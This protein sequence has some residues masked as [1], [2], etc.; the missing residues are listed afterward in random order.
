MWGCIE[1]CREHLNA[2]NVPSLYV[3]VYRHQREGSR[4]HFRSLTVCEGVSCKSVKNC[5]Q[6][7][8]PHYTWGCIAVGKVLHYGKDV[9]S[10]YVRVYR[11]EHREPMGRWGSL[12]I[13]DGI[14]PGTRNTR[15]VVWFP[16]YTWGYI[17]KVRTKAPGAVVPSL[18]VRAYLCFYFSR[19]T[20][21][22]EPAR[23]ITQK[24]RKK[25][26]A[27]D[28]FSILSIAKKQRRKK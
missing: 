12:I 5:F 28:F 24:T 20:A 21:D 26:C 27:P 7:W 23:D 10:L 8:F 1:H 3:R 2:V 18:Y 22:E 25:L 17:T 19:M 14:S 6:G 15:A 4:I 16:H 11:A 9:P 13:R